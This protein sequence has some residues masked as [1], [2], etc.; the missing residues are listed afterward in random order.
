MFLIGGE[1]PVFSMKNGINSFRAGEHEND[2]ISPIGQLCRGRSK[3]CSSIGKC[4]GFFL[5][6]VVDHEFITGFQDICGHWLPHNAQ[7]YKTD[8][9]DID[10]PDGL[11]DTANAMNG[12]TCFC[13]EFCQP[14]ITGNYFIL[15]VIT[16][17][18]AV[19]SRYLAHNSPC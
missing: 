8:F 19:N 12:V 9:F 13:I 6:A 2:D 4:S 17:R 16:F 3:K 10:A 1:N 15:R 11:F 14:V 5:C 18:T 7:T